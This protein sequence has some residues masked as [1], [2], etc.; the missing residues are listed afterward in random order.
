M[1]PYLCD[2]DERYLCSVIPDSELYHGDARAVAVLDPLHSAGVDL[3]VVADLCTLDEVF[4]FYKSSTF[5][6]SPLAS[7][8]MEPFMK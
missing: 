8:M 6:S 1:S 5:F 2:P 3:Q 7:W 4:R